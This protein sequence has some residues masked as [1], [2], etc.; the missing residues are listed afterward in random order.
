MGRER[1]HLRTPDPDPSVGS[2]VAHVPAASDWN[3]MDLLPESA[4]NAH[5]ICAAQLQNKSG[6]EFG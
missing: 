5:V 6:G 4:P 3:H 2:G 1:P